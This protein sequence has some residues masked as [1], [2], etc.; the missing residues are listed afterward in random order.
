MSEVCALIPAAGRGARFGRVDAAGVPR[1]KVF[2]PLLGRPLIGWTLEVIAR[3]DAIDR[4][5]LV[6]GEEDLPALREM[7]RDFGG[8][9]VADIVLGGEDRQTSVRRGLEACRDSSLVVVHDAARPCLTQDLLLET[10]RPVRRPGGAA[11]AT[12]AYPVADTLVRATPDLTIATS[13]DRS[14]LWAIQTPQVFRTE[15]LLEAHRIAQE[16]AQSAGGA[17]TSFTDDAGLMALINCPVYLVTGSSENLKVTRPEDLAFAEAILLRRQSLPETG[18]P[19][20]AAPPPDATAPAAAAPRDPAVA[21][22]PF[23]VGQG[24]DVHAFAEGRP[25]YLG[26]V[27]FPEAKRGL[28]GHSDADVLLHAVCDALLGAAGLGDIGRLFPPSDALHKDRPSIEFLQEV[29]ARLDAA[30]WLV[31]NVD[32]TVLAEEPKIGPRAD[33]IRARIAVVLDIETSQVSVK[34][35]TNER[36]GFVGRGEGIAAHATALL[37]NR[38][39]SGV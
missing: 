38:G 33:D 19:A 12:A 14:Q 30:G 35:T 20:L 9:K 22:C 8:G 36:M 5:V 7:A 16:Q 39:Q 23:R 37:Y 3:C 6:G 28:L 13:V 31:G 4:I 10:L 26:G 21:P 2:A 11:A 25:L 17:A 18:P 1:N 24:Y 32:V 29:K 15:R 27:A 34:A